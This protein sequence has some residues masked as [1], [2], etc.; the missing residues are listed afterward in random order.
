MCL[1]AEVELIPE[2]HCL[3]CVH[4]DSRQGEDKERGTSLVLVYAAW[5][6][7]AA[8]CTTQLPFLM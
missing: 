3:F 6:S 4:M 7:V 5:I 8:E 1:E 2:L